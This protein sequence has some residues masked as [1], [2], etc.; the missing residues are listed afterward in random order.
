MILPSHLETFTLITS[1]PSNPVPPSHSSIVKQLRRGRDL[2][3]QSLFEIEGRSASNV[4]EVLS[5]RA[6]VFGEELGEPLES[7][8]MEFA[9]H[10]VEGTIG[11]RS[12][13][14][15]QIGRAAPAFPLQSLA[16]TDRV[17]LEM[18]AFELLYPDEA[19]VEVAINEAVELAKTYGGES[20]GRFVNG[21]LGTIAEGLPRGE[22]STARSESSRKR[23]RGRSSG[24]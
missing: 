10:L 20:S 21:V 2:A 13:L 9:R 1:A 3:F 8:A 5:Q 6:H 19:P 14:D 15:E 11:E 17:I 4:E 24:R 12:Y 22:A 16:V 18:A 7:S 23:Q